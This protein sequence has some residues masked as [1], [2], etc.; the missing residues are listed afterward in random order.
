MKHEKTFVVTEQHIVDIIEH[1]EDSTF[2]YLETRAVARSFTPEGCLTPEVADV[3][4]DIAENGSIPWDGRPGLQTCYRNGWIHRMPM[5]K[6]YGNT[7]DVCVL[8]SRLHEK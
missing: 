6:A 1:D 8:P 2:N 7:S 5:S 3:L 4:S